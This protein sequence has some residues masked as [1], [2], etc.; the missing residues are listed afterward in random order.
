MADPDPAPE[1]IR[2]HMSCS[3]SGTRRENCPV[4]LK[5]V[6]ENIRRGER[7]STLSDVQNSE[8][9]IKEDR[10]FLRIWHS[11]PQDPDTNPKLF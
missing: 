5:K 6:L 1:R 11:T 9:K 10:M 3:G 7:Y 2:I 4:I 8:L